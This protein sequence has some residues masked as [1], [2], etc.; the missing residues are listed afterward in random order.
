MT[1]PPPSEILIDHYSD[2]LCVWAYVAQI[3]VEE[4]RRNFAGRVAVRYHFVPVFGSSTK[5]IG[6]GWAERGGF[7]G[8]AKHAREVC[9]EFPH[10]RMSPDAWERVRPASS[11][12][13]HVFLKAVH[14][15]E[16]SGPSPA[17]GLFERAAWALR[18]AFFVDARDVSR[19]SVQLEIAEQVGA[20]REGIEA[21]MDDGTAMAAVSEDAEAQA[22]HKIEG[23]PTLVFNG[24]RQKLYGNVGYR[25]L[26]ANVDEALRAGD[27]LAASWC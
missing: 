3:R 4:L 11:A 20:P 25:I 14:L 27:P 1:S 13:A 19:R 16:G 23:S 6:G 9:E 10:V 8:Y 2:V 15:H 22:A 17:G 26:E 21:A 5:K 18:C 24:G 12:S 7:A